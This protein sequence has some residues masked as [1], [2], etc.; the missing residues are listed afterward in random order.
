MKVY[1]CRRCFSTLHR[2]SDTR[3]LLCPECNDKVNIRALDNRC[4][5]E[6]VIPAS[7]LP[8]VMEAEA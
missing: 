8:L 3:K 4:V 5:A 2:C 1:I 7:E 6:R